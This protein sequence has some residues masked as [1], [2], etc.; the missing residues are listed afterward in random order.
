M[1][2]EFEFE[3][4]SSTD[5]FLS[6]IECYADNK[7]C[8]SYYGV[9]DAHSFVLES[10]SPNRSV[11][12]TTYFEVPK[13]AELIELEIESDSWSNEKITFVIK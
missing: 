6:S 7:K 2:A 4:I 1:C 9:D 5:Q 11:S 13:D 8:E 10:I 12:G 3:N